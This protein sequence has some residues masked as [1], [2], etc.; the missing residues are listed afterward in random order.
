[1]KKILLLF[2]CLVATATYAQSTH[3]LPTP[4]QVQWQKGSFVWNEDNVDTLIVDHLEVPRNEDQAY[5]LTVS[6]KAI[7]MEATTETGVFYATQSLRQLYRH[8]SLNSAD[9]IVRIPCMTITDWP[10]FKLRGWQD[11]ISRGPIV[12]MDYLKQLIP[13]MA[14]CKVNFFSLYTEHTFKT[15]SHPDIAPEDAF[16][17]E[18]IK[19]LEAFCKRYHVEII[20]NQ[21]CF[22]HCEKILKNPFYEHLADTRYNLNPGI[23]ATYSFL[24]DIIREEAA[25][26]SHP[27]FNIN[28]DETESL[29][30]GK[31][32]DY[33]R[34]VGKEKAYYQHIN[35]VNEIVKRYG[36]RAMMWGDIADQHP[37]IIENLDKDIILLAWSYVG[38]DSFDKFL[39]PYVSSGHDFMVVP[40]VS[41]SERVWPNQREF[42]RNIPNLCRDGFYHGAFGM[43]NT[44]WDDFGDSQTNEALYGLALGAEMGWN[45]VKKDETWSPQDEGDRQTKENFALHFLGN[46]GDKLYQPLDDVAEMAQEDIAKFSS[47]TEKMVPFYP[48][49]V[50][51]TIETYYKDFLKTWFGEGEDNIE[52]RLRQAREKARRNAGIFDNA[53]FAAHRIQW[54]ANRNITRCQLYRTFQDPDEANVNESKRQIDELLAS[55]HQ[56]K[57]EYIKVWEQESRPCWLDVDMEKYNTVA[58]DLQAL[59]YLPFIDSHTDDD[60]QVMIT[61]RTLYKD[62]PIH[63]TIDGKDVD[64]TDPVYGQPFPITRSCLVKAACFDAM[65]RPVGKERYFVYHKG[66]GKLKV[67]NSPAGNYRPEY[68]AGGD[69]ALLDG[70]LGSKDYKDGRWQGFYGV[71]AD[72][73]LDFKQ[74]EPINDIEIGFLVNPHDWILRANQV[75]IL[76][77]NDGQHYKLFQTHDIQA[78]TDQANNVVFKERIPTKGL[79]TRYLK[80]IVKNPGLIPEGLP[81]HGFDSWIFMDEIIIN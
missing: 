16:T 28:C 34:K 43:M 4:Q 37:E 41:L 19:E 81:G 58:K 63:Y 49:Q 1:M 57:C 67:L 73:E 51:D 25:T 5:R 54:C 60:G 24:D 14:E 30:N 78:R 11:D 44:C 66:M 53:L 23:E 35:R 70:L 6:E 76:T 45:P 68:S 48:S 12:T 71:D 64:T 56:L 52:Y 33:V 18:E 79:K 75:E 80:I 39:Q 40:G 15:E 26:Y 13:Q 9:G 20:G 46:S 17:A 3:I 22:A 65:G 55:L 2:L 7:R 50:H 42:T 32:R 36:K 77:S 62:Q 10:D 61:I 8:A 31:G 29:G 21:Q 59:P 38:I 74:K 27:L 72:I 47:M 69:N